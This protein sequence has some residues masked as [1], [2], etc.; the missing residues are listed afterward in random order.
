MGGVQSCQTA[1][2]RENMEY[3]GVER[4]EGLT[5]RRE[6]AKEPQMDTNERE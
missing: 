6:R 1:N 3:K 4:R 2:F 5:Q